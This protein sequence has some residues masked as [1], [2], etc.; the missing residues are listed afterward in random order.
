MYVVLPP[1]PRGLSGRGV[2]VWR[3]SPDIAHNEVMHVPNFLDGEQRRSAAITWAMSF[4][5]DPRRPLRVAGDL[6]VLLELLVTDRPVLLEQLLD[7]FQDERVAFKRGRVVRFL[8]PDLF[9]DLLSFFWER[10]SA[11]AFAKLEDMPLEPFVDGSSCRAAF[12]CWDGVL[13]KLGC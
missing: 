7:L 2:G 11:Q 10:K 13:P 8:M 5:V 3:V 12:G 4:L 6:H 9:P 1:V